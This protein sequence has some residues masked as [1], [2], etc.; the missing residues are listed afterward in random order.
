MQ[1]LFQVDVVLGDKAQRS[2]YGRGHQSAMSFQESPCA[3]RGVTSSGSLQAPLGHSSPPR[4]LAPSPD[5]PPTPEDRGRGFT[6]KQR[7]QKSKILRHWCR[8]LPLI[9]LLF[10]T[11]LRGN[12]CSPPTAN[13]CI[14]M[15][16]EK[17]SEVNTGN[18]PVSIQALHY[19]DSFL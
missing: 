16:D 5:S 12:Y 1:I 8:T 9:Q 6:S 10:V 3:T 11:G 7:C 4:S 2:S 14:C 19:P 15:Q 13:C 17:R 18:E